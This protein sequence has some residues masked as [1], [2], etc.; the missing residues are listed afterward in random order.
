MEDSIADGGLASPGES[1]ASA[2][3]NACRDLAAASRVFEAAEAAARRLRI[4]LDAQF[5]RAIDAIT[6]VNRRISVSEL[7]KS[8]L[9]G[10]KIAATLA[11]TGAPAYFVHPSEASHRVLPS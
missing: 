3:Q 8:G 7:G 6:A 11:S 9:I 1:A 5:S 4:G 2:R 10:R